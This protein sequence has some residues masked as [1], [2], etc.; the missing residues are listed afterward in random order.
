LRGSVDEIV[1]GQVTR[2]E[3]LGQACNGLDVVFSSVGIT[4][5]K[6]GLTFRDVDYRGNRNLFDIALQA[7]VRKFVYVSVLNGPW[8]RHLDIVAA[9]EQVVDELKTSGID[10]C[11]LRPTGYFSDM[12][13]FFEMARKGRVYL[14]GSGGNRVNPIHEA[15]LAVQCADAIEGDRREIDVGGP[16][17]MTWN[18]VARLAFASQDKPPK[19]TRIPAWLVW[20]AVRLVRLF[21]R[22]QGEL[23]AFFATMGTSDVVAPAVGSHCLEEHFREFHSEAVTD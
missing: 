5:Q 15:D 6:D 1:E 21:N 12:G 2:P 4:Q 9:H 22:H 14:V 11:V 23:L 7:G 16:D 18:E 3:T 8:L 17:I 13:V 19:V 10:Y 20:S